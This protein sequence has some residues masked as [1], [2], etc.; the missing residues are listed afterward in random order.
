MLRVTCDS[1][2][3]T[4]TL[5][6]THSVTFHKYFDIRTLLKSV[7]YGHAYEFY[8]Y[9]HTR[10]LIRA[11]SIRTHKVWQLSWYW[12]YRYV[13]MRYVKM[14]LAQKMTHDK[15]KCACH[16]LGFDPGIERDTQI[17]AQLIWP[18]SYYPHVCIRFY[19]GAVTVIAILHVSESIKCAYA[20]KKLK[21]HAKQKDVTHR[22]SYAYTHTLTHTRYGE[23]IIHLPNFGRHFFYT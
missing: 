10:N 14:S 23:K 7:M 5:C 3:N 22:V 12:N 6:R 15:K 16:Q 11:T 8:A 4:I 1:Y 20:E 19:T 2:R 13:H 9:T 17:N 18:L 21:W